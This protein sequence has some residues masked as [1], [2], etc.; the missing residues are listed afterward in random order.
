MTTRTLPRFAAHV[1]TARARMATA[2]KV[3]P[4]VDREYKRSKDGKFASGGGGVRQSLQDAK[5]TEE[6]QAA[7]ASEY[8]AITGRS[9]SYARMTGSDVQVA[10]EHAEGILRGAERFPETPI[11]TV[12]TYG[13]EGSSHPQ[14]HVPG[15]MDAYAVTISNPD[16]SFSIGFQVGFA[17]DSGRYLDSLARD[18][19]A[20]WLARGSGNPTGVAIHEFGHAVAGTA[21][22]NAGARTTAAAAAREAGTST[23]F[24]VK[25]SVSDYAATSAHELAAEAFTDV[26]MN[27][28][29]ASPLSQEIFDGIE[30]KYDAK[31]GGR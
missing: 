27:G 30:G 24:H 10:R 26:M 18:A 9:M 23:R 17:G 28:D 13:G 11:A 22:A 14:L 3:L 12:F 31:Y 1:A 7:L 25:A 16:G 8:T 4:I 15:A 20:S 19:A 21:R 2:A 29:S 5:T 6:V